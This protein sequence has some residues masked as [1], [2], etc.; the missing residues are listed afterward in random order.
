MNLRTLEPLII[1]AAIMV[2]AGA[3][4]LTSKSL[5]R[6]ETRHRAV[7][8]R[9]ERLERTAL[10]GSL[11]EVLTDPRYWA[12]NVTSTYLN[13]TGPLVSNRVDGAEDR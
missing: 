7:E 3:A 2:C 13:L 6:H 10:T 1:V 4:S 9:L 12:N 11:E 8:D 5:T